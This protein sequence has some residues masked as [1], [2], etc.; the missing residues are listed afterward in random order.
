MDVTSFGMTV[1]LHPWM[2]FPVAVSI[3]AL[4]LFLESYIVLSRSISM[5]VSPLQPRKAPVLMDVTLL[6][7][8]TDLRPLQPQ[9][10]SE[11]IDVTLLGMVT[12]VSPLQ[13]S[14]AA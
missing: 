14:K 6:G 9:K 4:Q 3:I 5:D 7:M 12:D 1:V 10:A 13:P 8:V 11:P 2:S